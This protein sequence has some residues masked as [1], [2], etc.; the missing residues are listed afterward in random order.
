MYKALIAELKNVRKHSNADRLQVAEIVGNQVIVGLDAKDGDVGVFFS[1]DDG[2]LCDIFCKENNLY[3]HSNKNKDTTKEG[4]LE[5]NGKIKTIRL[6]KEKSEGIFLPLESLSFTGAK[7]D[8]L[9]VGVAFDTINKVK[10]CEKYINPATLKRQNQGSK[11]TKKSNKENYPI[12]KEHKSTEQLLYHI[13]DIKKGSLVTLT[14]KVHGTSQ[15]TQHTRKDIVLPTWK[16]TI[17]KVLPLF[18]TFEWEVVTGTRRV[19]LDDF[20]NPK[21]LGFYG[22]NEFRKPYHDFLEDKLYK[23]E[24]LYYEL[25]GWAGIDSPIM[26]KCENKRTKDKE[27]IKKYGD[28]TIFTYGCQ[29]GTSDM[30]VYRMTMTNEDGVTVE[31]PWYMVKQRCEDM[32]VKAVLE[33]E[34]SFIFDGDHDALVE[35]VKQYAEGED[36]IDPSH[37]R[38]GVVVRTERR[39]KFE[40]FKFKSYYF[41]VLE[42][43]IKESNVVDMEEE[44]GE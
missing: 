7:I 43:I 25:V 5:D 44:Q 32:G 42:G 2:K 15:R 41:K 18:K 31:Y 35:K 8:K 17:N 11:Q 12:F 33:F 27:F 6:R 37:I 3:R 1:S 39:N 34:P 36:L 16:K 10:V 24:T 14:S 4:Y 40:A 28:T 21:K 30:Y 13:N 19:I 38:E 20:N 23:G 26:S 9:K 29:N 22:T